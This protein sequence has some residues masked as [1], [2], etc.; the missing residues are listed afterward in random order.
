MSKRGAEV[1]HKKDLVVLYKIVWQ[2]LNANG[3]AIE[4]V[5]V[6]R[7]FLFYNTINFYEKV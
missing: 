5:N 7:F 1:Y 3:Q 4:R 6:E 2:A